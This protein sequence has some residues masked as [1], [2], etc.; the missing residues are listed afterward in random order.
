[1]PAEPL[2]VTMPHA[3][4][5]SQNGLLVEGWLAVP[6]QLIESFEVPASVRLPPLSAMDEK[7]LVVLFDAKVQE[8]VPPLLKFRPWSSVRVAGPAAVPGAILPVPETLP[9]MRPSPLKVRRKY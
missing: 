4:G 2:K 6:V 1:M 8:Y 7:T 9:S 5:T 3:S